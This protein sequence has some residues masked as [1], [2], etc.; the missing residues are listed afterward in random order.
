MCESND[1]DETNRFKKYKPNVSRATGRD[2]CPPDALT[3]NDVPAIDAR[4]EYRDAIDANLRHLTPNLA[5]RSASAYRI[6]S[7]PE[8]DALIDA[9]DLVLHDNAS[10]RDETDL[11]GRQKKAVHRV[12]SDAK[13]IARGLRAAVD[14]LET[15]ENHPDSR[16]IESRELG[17]WVRTRLEARTFRDRDKTPG[18]EGTD[19]L[20]TDGGRDR[21]SQITEGPVKGRR[22]MRLDS[23]TADGHACDNPR[24]AG[25]AEV[26][27]PDGYLC[28]ECADAWKEGDL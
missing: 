10:E 22:D 13:E 27:T 23:F 14:E 17:E 20:R 8:A 5:D 28:G 9:C 26:V 24:C 7:L 18:L 3:L 2:I 25:R 4:G 12:K 16:R 15:T 11:T 6:E 21:G 19:E 1:A